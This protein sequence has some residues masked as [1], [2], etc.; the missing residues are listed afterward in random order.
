MHYYWSEHGIR[1]SV[2]SEM[3]T[4][5]LAFVRGSYFYEI[6]EANKEMTDK[7]KLA[8]EGKA[9]PTFVI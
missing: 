6:E 2:F 4:N 9:Y 5:E 3:T 7:I 8:N 1:P